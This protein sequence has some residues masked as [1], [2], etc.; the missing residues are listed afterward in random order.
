MEKHS[1]DQ[2][3]EVVAGDERDGD[4]GV[5]AGEKYVLRQR[6]IVEAGPALNVPNARAK[7][8]RF[9]RKAS[10]QETT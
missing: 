2:L 8:Y 9:Y 7:G 6:P 3:V 4:V 5:F 1:V 10:S